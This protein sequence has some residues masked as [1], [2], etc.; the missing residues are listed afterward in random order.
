MRYVLRIQFTASNNEAEYEVLLHGMRIAKA[1]GAKRLVIYGDSKLVV[2]QTMNKCDALSD[3]MIAYHDLYDALEGDFVGCDLRHVG[4]ER[5]EEADILANIGSTC[6][7]VPPGVFLERIYERSIK[8]KAPEHKAS[9]TKDSRGYA[10]Q[11]A[12]GTQ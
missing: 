3:N 12:N 1:C 9:M 7:Q 6:T 5:N 4:R 8:P 10:T 2:N 11:R